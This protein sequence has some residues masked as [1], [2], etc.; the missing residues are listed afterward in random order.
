MRSHRK[1]ERK[2]IDRKFNYSQFGTVIGLD[3]SLFLRIIFILSIIVGLQC[4][5]NF[6]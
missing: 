1:K 2:E 5:V 4:S 3:N 6:L